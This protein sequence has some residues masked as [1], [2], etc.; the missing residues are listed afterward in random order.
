M[1]NRFEFRPYIRP[2]RQPLKTHYGEW[3]DRAGILLRLTADDERVGYGEIAPVPWFG[4]ETLEQALEWCQRLPTELPPDTIPAISNSLPAC[5]FGFESAW[6]AMSTEM[7]QPQLPL[8]ALLP[9][10]AAA[11][12]AW[13]PLWKAGYRTFKW[14]IAVATPLQELK[15]FECL[16]QLLPVDAKLRLDANGGLTLEQATEWLEACDRNTVEYLEQPLPPHQFQDLLNLQASFATTLALDESVATLQ[17]LQQCYEQGWRSVV[18]V[19]PA[20]AGSPAQLRQ[21]CQTYL[22]DAVFSSVF[23]TAIGRQAGL[24]LA[25]ELGNRARAVGYGTTHWFE[26]DLQKFDALWQTL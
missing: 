26:H 15:W 8:S 22:I 14:K 11:L 20:I 3:R 16:K 13:K 12:S 6:E 2:F 21:F 10:G 4:S 25:A 9:A 5:Q 19:K 24:R 18:V 1:G 23:E 17:Q 7:N